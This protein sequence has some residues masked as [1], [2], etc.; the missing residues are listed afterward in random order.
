MQH[1]NSHGIEDAAVEK[2]FIAALLR[3]NVSMGRVASSVPPEAL[4]DPKCQALYLAMMSLYSLGIDF[5][6]IAVCNELIKLDMYEAAGKE[7]GVKGFMEQSTD[8]DPVVLGRIVLDLHSRRLEVELSDLIQARAYNRAGGEDNDMPARL[9]HVQGKLQELQRLS[10]DDA[11]SL[12]SDDFADYYRT[13]MNN[14]LSTVDTPKM[15]F[16]WPDLNRL[17]PSF[18]GGDMMILVAES[19]AGK[20]SLME[21]QA[22]FLWEEGYHGVFYHLELSTTR[23]ADRRMAR[24][25]GIP[26]RALQDGR[27]EAEGRKAY[28]TSEEQTLVDG[29]IAR[30]DSWP[31][32][33]ALKHCPGWTMPKICADIRLRADSGKLD[34]VV[35]D[36]F[37]KVG[38][39]RKSGSYATFDLGMSIEVYKATLEEL[40]LFGLMAAQFPKGNDRRHRRTVEDA[41]DTKELA[42]K[43]NIGAVLDRPVDEATGRRQAIAELRITK[44]NVGEEGMV[45]LLFEGARFRFRNMVARSA[46]DMLDTEFPNF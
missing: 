26:L 4:I 11:Q 28:L 12:S 21:D 19:G 24:A 17:S 38:L 15:R 20:T 35:I 32:S 27:G 1:L 30:Q 5:E 6:Q 8:A 33:L 2:T 18:V 36:Y 45:S 9:A 40:L 34:F 43:A 39:I 3:N 13:L 14:R 44:C 23:M 29:A 31:G 37:N 22:E 41:R 42:D 10:F 7:G 46:L 25:T 16:K